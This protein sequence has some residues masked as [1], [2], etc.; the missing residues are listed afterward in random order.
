MT[1]EISSC[2]FAICIIKSSKFISFIEMWYQGDSTPGVLYIQYQELF[3]MLH[4]Q[5]ITK[6]LALIWMSIIVFIYSFWI[7]LLLNFP[8]VSDTFK[9]S[10]VQKLFPAQLML[11]WFPHHR[12]KVQ[13][14]FTLSIVFILPCLKETMVAHYPFF[15]VSKESLRNHMKPPLF[16][17]LLLFL[18]LCLTFNS[19]S[20]IMYIGS[21]YFY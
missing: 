9:P 13:I 6:V 15:C 19:K 18:R 17:D 3:L 12:E 5:R 2:H 21:F 10:H 16:T 11:L 4:I 20:N 8:L 14:S 7:Y 1:H